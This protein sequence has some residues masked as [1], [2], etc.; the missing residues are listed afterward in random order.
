MNTTHRQSTSNLRAFFKIKKKSIGFRNVWAGL[1][2]IVEYNWTSGGRSKRKSKTSTLH[3]TTTRHRQSPTMADFIVEPF[4]LIWKISN[5]RL[6]L[7]SKSLDALTTQFQLKNSSVL[8]MVIKTAD[9]F[10]YS[11]SLQFPDNAT[12]PDTF[13]C[14]ILDGDFT[15]KKMGQ[16]LPK[17]VKGQY[18]DQCDQ[19]DQYEQYD[20]YG[21]LITSNQISFTLDLSLLS[22]KSGELIVSVQCSGWPLANYMLSETSI[23]ANPSEFKVNSSKYV[24]SMMPFTCEMADDNTFEWFWTKDKL[25]IL[26][27]PYLCQVGV[28]VERTNSTATFHLVNESVTAT[29]FTSLK[30]VFTIRTAA[31]KH[32]RAIPDDAQVVAQDVGVTNEQ[33]DRFEIATLLNLSKFSDFTIYVDGAEIPAHRIVLSSR[34]SVLRELLVTNERLD[35]LI[36]K[37]FDKE[38]IDGMLHHMYTGKL[39]TIVSQ[40]LLLAANKYGV[41]DLKLACESVLSGDITMDNVEQMLVLSEQ[42]GAEELKVRTIAFVCANLTKLKSPRLQSVFRSYPDLAF[43]LFMQVTK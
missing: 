32:I 33:P 1:G 22:E 5:F 38:S 36:V 6:Y 13:V 40:Q 2:G 7:D 8:K 39:P 17:L 27:C 31:G 15:K 30:M 16:I 3:N 9:K 29:E 42:A 41:E 10:K 4:Q 14:S 25:R 24:D 43:D 12:V 20:Q 34:S 19:Y 37:D 18:Y 21:M 28:H 35:K 11:L 26:N 23:V